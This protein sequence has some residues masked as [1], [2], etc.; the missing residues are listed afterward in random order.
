M[1]TVGIDLFGLIRL[2]L[3]YGEFVYPNS[4]V[5]GIDL[6][7]LI[8]LKQLN[9]LLQMPWDHSRDWS[10]WIDTIETILTP[11]LHRSPLYRRDWSVWIDTIE[12]LRFSF[13]EPFTYHMS[14]L[15]C[16]D[17][18]DWNFLACKPAFTGVVVSG[19]ICLDWYDW[20]A[21]TELYPYSSLYK[22][23]LI[24]LDWYDWN[25]SIE[26]HNHVIVSG[27]DWSVWI[28]TI[29]T[30][31]YLQMSFVDHFVGIDLFG[32]IRLKLTSMVIHH[33]NLTIVGIDLFGLIRL[34]PTLYKYR[35]WGK[36]SRDWSVWIDT[37]ET[38]RMIELN[39]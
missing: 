21:D 29:E 9:C 5:V 17:W 13:W 1:S 33:F 22:S 37:I 18:Y 36:K 26:K 10:V 12:T 19:L 15:I 23:G 32:L 20:N 28:D 14:G 8:R 27:R 6:F 30:L 39:S 35:E 25:G 7:G 11:V 2:K 31:M 3:V 16:L 24:C 34:K 4:L 38:S